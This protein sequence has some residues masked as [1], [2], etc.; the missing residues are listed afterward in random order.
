MQQA[1]LA[2]SASV[3]EVAE[4]LLASEVAISQLEHTPAPAS[5]AGLQQLVAGTNAPLGSL[6]RKEAVL[7][8]AQQAGGS[9]GIPGEG[10][11]DRLSAASLDA[12]DGLCRPPMAPQIPAP[13][14]H[15]AAQPG[16]PPQPG[17]SSAR[18]PPPQP[19]LTAATAPRAA[20]AVSEPAAPPTPARSEPG[21]QQRQPNQMASAQASS[22]RLA[23]LTHALRRKQQLQQS[24]PQGQPQQGASAARKGVAKEEQ[25]GSFQESAAAP[26]V[27]A[28]PAKEGCGQQRVWDAST[29]S[30]Q[31]A[32]G[33]TGWAAAR[34]NGVAA[35]GRELRADRA[36]SGQPVQSG[37]GLRSMECG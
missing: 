23:L 25:G 12:L 7:A 35:T 21:R 24:Q 18:P 20:A 34:E 15:N 1:D 31:P 11:L 28:P 3:Q 13:G 33:G 17:G 9:G 14:R 19:S 26:V 6:F 36:V 16:T 5:M 37:E 29:N 8:K 30:L 4:A 32:Q 2:C 10:A 27:R 22:E